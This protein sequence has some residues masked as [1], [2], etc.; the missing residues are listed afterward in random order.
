MQI[1]PMG[2]ELFHAD[3]RAVGL[4][5]GQLTDSH[6]EANNS[7]SQFREGTSNLSLSTFHFLVQT[8]AVQ[9]S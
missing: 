4:I 7:F 8:E 3:R 5:D 2:A 6:G 9:R 1:R